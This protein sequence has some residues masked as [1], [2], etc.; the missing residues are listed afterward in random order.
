MGITYNSEPMKYLYSVLLQLAVRYLLEHPLLSIR[1][2]PLLGIQTLFAYTI[3]F[4]YA[5]SLA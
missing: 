5:L 3:S 4:S 2:K 1:I